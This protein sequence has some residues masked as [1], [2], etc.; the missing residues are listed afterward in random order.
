MLILGSLFF[1]CFLHPLSQR[2]LHFFPC[3]SPIPFSLVIHASIAS[4]GLDISRF[5]NRNSKRARVKDGLS[6]LSSPRY[7]YLFPNLAISCF[8]RKSLKLYMCSGLEVFVCKMI[9]AISHQSK[10]NDMI[11][12]SSFFLFCFLIAWASPLAHCVHL[13]PHELYPLSLILFFSCSIVSN[14]RQ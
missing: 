3:F 14:S 8:S 11:L 6:T 9:N 13:P 12:T 7:A 2:L 10:E 1:F 5:G 4:R